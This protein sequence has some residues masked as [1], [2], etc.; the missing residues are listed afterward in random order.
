M[1][2]RNQNLR[3]FRMAEWGRFEKWKANAGLTAKA[4][5]RKKLRA[6]LRP[7]SYRDSKL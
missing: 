6:S 7:D 4:L 3:I 1:N 5:K 2:S